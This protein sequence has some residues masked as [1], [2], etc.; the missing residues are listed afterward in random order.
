V[1]THSISAHIYEHDYK[2]V[3]KVPGLI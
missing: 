2:N 1:S 3:E